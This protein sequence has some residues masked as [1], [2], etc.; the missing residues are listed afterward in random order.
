[1]VVSIIAIASLLLRHASSNCPSSAKVLAKYDKYI[2]VHNVDPVDRHAVIPEVIVWTAFEASPVKVNSKP[3][4]IIPPAFHSKAPFSS[5]S[6][7][8]SSACAF[9]AA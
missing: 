1:L 2:G 4:V 8:T 9:A 7:A 6:A 3:C 5:P